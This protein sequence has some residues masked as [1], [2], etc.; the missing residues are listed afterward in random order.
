M[1]KALESENDEEMQVKKLKRELKERNL[2][3]EDG[4]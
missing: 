2:D 3:Y 1:V 4:T